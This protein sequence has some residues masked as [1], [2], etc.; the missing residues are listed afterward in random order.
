MRHCALFLSAVLLAVSCG[1]AHQGPITV[2]ID[3]AMKKPFS[4]RDLYARADAIPLHCP[5]GTVF[6]REGHGVMDI[7][8][9]RFF[10]LDKEKNGI[11]VFDWDGIYITTV[12]SEQAIIDFSVYQERIL[13]V[14]TENAIT[15]YA[16]KDGALLESYPLRN[17]E[18]ILKSVARVDE[19]SIALLGCLDGEMYDCGYLIDRNYFYSL[20]RPAPD[21]LLTHA[22]VPA[23]E[24][25]DSRYFR[26]GD[27]VY[28]FL[29]RSGQ[30]DRFTGND[31]IVPA[32]QWD[33]GKR[34]PTFTNAQKSAD[35]VYLAFDLDGQRLV[36]IYDLKDGDYKIVRQTDFPLGVIYD[37]SYYYCCSASR[38]PDLLHSALPEETSG[39][40][41]IRYAL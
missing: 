21:Y 31:F 28:S 11:L 13:D 25:Q 32:Y 41:I 26:C 12:K 2:N 19:D 6:G 36:L 37:G 29:S 30:I 33:F 39:P 14:L 23:S 35:L 27:A 9:D 24:M 16:T 18:M 34:S 15:E 4:T 3:R 5:D 38:L 8:A 22:T 7:A 10:L 1:Q 20:P 40:V 17:G